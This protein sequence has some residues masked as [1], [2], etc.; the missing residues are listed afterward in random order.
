MTHSKI[1]NSLNTVVDNIDT[2]SLCFATWL[3][4]SLFLWLWLLATLCLGF[5]I[6]M[7]TRMLVRAVACAV[8]ELSVHYYWRYFSSLRRVTFNSQEK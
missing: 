4:W 3:V 5:V 8:T 7:L 6:H 2:N 1:C